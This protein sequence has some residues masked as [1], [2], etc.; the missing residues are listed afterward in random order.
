MSTVEKILDSKTNEGHHLCWSCQEEIDAGPFCKKCVKIQ[1]VDNL[2]DYFSL[3]GFSNSYKIDTA[4]L[5][6]RFYELSRKFHPDFYSEK[7]LEEKTIACDNAAFLN[8]AYK[9]LSD[10]IKR[11]EYLLGLTSGHITRNPQPPQELFD[12][13]LDIGELLIKEGLSNEDVTTL[14]NALS[15]FSNAQEEIVESLAQ[16]FE[17]DKYFD[18][19]SKMN[20]YKYL[21]SILKKIKVKLSKDK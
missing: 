19:E 11:A 2:E 20:D 9:V 21:Q 7:N 13:I 6:K 16:L 8:R 4:E 15:E 18:I 10:P 3:F 5:K 17:R 1:P 12:E 14:R